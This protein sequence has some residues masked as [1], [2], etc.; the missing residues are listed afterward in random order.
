VAIAAVWLHARVE[1]RAAEA[2]HRE[3]HIRLVQQRAR[4]G[5][6][7]AQRAAMRA[8]TLGRALRHPEHGRGPEDVLQRER[9]LADLA[10]D[11]TLVEL[12]AAARGATDLRGWVADAPLATSA[13]AAV[14][15]ALLGARL[16]RTP[17]GRGRGHV[18][19]HADEPAPTPGAADGETSSRGRS[20]EAGIA[21][22]L[23]AAVLPLFERMLIDALRPKDRPVSS[24]PKAREASDAEA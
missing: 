19:A 9:E 5:R 6:D 4:A 1:A 14:A 16:G 22:P 24:A 11:Q 18:A 15:G 2:L 13:A 7:S 10:L 17:P 23:L 20:A 3:R 8:A 12:G 21:G